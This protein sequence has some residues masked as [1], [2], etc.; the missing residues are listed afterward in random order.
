MRVWF[1]HWFSTAYHLVNLIKA[2]NPDEFTMV[3]SSWNE[4]AIYKRACDEW[5]EEPKNLDEAQYVEFCLEFCKN[6]SIDIFVP[7]TKLVAIVENA[8][9]FKELG[10]TLFADTNAETVRM[11]SDKLDT[12]EYFKEKGFECIPEIRVVNSVD[13]FAKAYEELNATYSR[14]CY[15]LTVDEGAMSFRVIDDNVNSL[16]AVLERP[17]AKI[18]LDNA[19]RVLEQYDFSIPVLLMPY[20]DE[21]EVSVDCLSTANGNIMVPRFKAG[22][23][24]SEVIFDKEVM[25]LCE[26]MINTLQIKMPMNIQF[27]KRDGKLY[28]LEINT[29]MSGGL[30]LS[31]EATGINIPSIAINQL[32]GNELQWAYP[33]ITSQRLANIE[34]PICLY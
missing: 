12:Y 25:E 16:S 13:E 31:C 34:T 24:Y 3:G 10:V 15:K 18:S 14:V 32:L 2:G 9:R 17:G 27:K 28:L 1:N 22:S 4:L 21:V 20:L 33:E 29:R 5:Y 30:Q 19:L 6:H 23:R 11:L 8:D 26:R 7:R